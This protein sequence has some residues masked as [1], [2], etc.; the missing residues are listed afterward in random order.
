MVMPNV[1]D[2]VK[3]PKG[4]TGR[5]GSSPSNKPRPVLEAPQPP[6]LHAYVDITRARPPNDSKRGAWHDSGLVFCLTTGK[7]LDAASVRREPPANHQEGGDRETWSPRELRHSFIS[8]TS[9]GGVPIEAIADL[10]GHSSPAVTGKVYRHQLK[11]SIT[12]ADAV[13]GPGKSA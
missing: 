5:A 10:C 1:A 9:D 3:T 4:T 6:R 12:R 8:I 13:F 7:P 2:L 11:P